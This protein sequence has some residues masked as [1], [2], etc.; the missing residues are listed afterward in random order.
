MSTGSPASAST[1]ASKPRHSVATGGVT[2]YMRALAIMRLPRYRR[3]DP[4]PPTVGPVF[5]T[6][7]AWRARPMKRR[8]FLK[9]ASLAAGTMP[10]FARRTLAQKNAAKTLRII[11]N[12]NLASL[13]PIWTTAPPTKDYAFLTFDQLVA[14]DSKYVAQP[15][16]AEGWT[17]EEDGK[18]YVLGLREGLKFH[19]GEP[20]RSSDCIASIQRWGARDGFGQLTMKF[21]DSFEAIDDRRFRIKLKK[22]FAL[23][24]AALGKSNSSQCF[25]MPERMAKV[26]PMKQVTET[27]GSGPY[28][29]LKGEFVSGA[30][31]AWAKFE[32][33]IP[34]K[35]PVDTIA[36][37]R[38]PAGSRIECAF[39]RQPST[40]MAALQAGEQDYWD[41]PPLDLIK[42]L[43]S[44]P[45]I[46]V[47]PRNPTGSYYML[48]L[49]H[50]HPPFN[51]QKLRPPLPT[52]PAHTASPNSPL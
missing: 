23:L 44:D 48:Q 2:E 34:R 42:V 24:P 8:H 22:P 41:A 43:K 3:F 36:G 35:G 26:D 46:V 30:R 49:N 6:P 20:V 45:S 47:S 9:G 12:G 33:Y 29:F 1:A 16:M 28:R 18:A 51:N 14:V 37:G 31:A 17:V 25:I 39:L 32:G 40:A 27:I 5:A 50:T 10:A 4:T 15:Q 38:L 7:V 52:P 13:D 21:V 11:H 19:D